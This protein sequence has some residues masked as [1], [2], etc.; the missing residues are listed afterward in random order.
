[1]DHQ[2]NRVNTTL[3]NISFSS[4]YFVIERHI[5]PSITNPKRSIVH[6]SQRINPL[7]GIP[8]G[9]NPRPP[10]PN[11]NE[12]PPQNKRKRDDEERPST[13]SDKRNQ[14]NNQPL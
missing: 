11:L 6:P 9:V 8:V 2:G 4:I 13:A 10:V 7:V 5:E 3:S 12:N 14:N 1:M